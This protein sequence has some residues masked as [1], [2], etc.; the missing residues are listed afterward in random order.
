[1]S[2]VPLAED[3]SVVARRRKVSPEL[4]DV[5]VHPSIRRPV[6][7]LIPYLPEA[8]RKRTLDLVNSGYDSASQF[9]PD[10][11][12][13]DTLAMMHYGVH[14]T[15]TSN[16]K[17]SMPPDGGPPG[18]SPSFAKEQLLDTYNIDAALL[19][20]IFNQARLAGFRIAD[21]KLN[22]ALVSAYNDYMLDVWYGT[23]KRFRWAL[24][25]PLGNMDHSPLP[26]IDAAVAEINRLGSHPG[27]AGIAL[28]QTSIRWGNPLWHPVYEAAVK[29]GL[30]ITTHAGW[31]SAFSF[32]G[33][34]K[35]PVGLPEIWGEVY[36]DNTF[37][38]AAHITSLVM[39][40]VF[41][42]YPTLKL[43]FLEWGATF[44]LPHMWRLDSAW[45]RVRGTVQGARRWPSEI[46]HDQV[47][48][49]TQPIDEPKDKRQFEKLVE[50]YLSDIFCF[51]T[52][53][54]HFDADTP[55]AT[56]TGLSASTKRKIFAENAKAVLRL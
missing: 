32:A 45:P 17:D 9:Q 22:A 50:T 52:D 38:A 53:Y 31:G 15:G 12:R 41:E 19:T 54:P 33:N 13:V 37:Q 11:I 26:D 46:I 51:A 28:N 35:Y 5:D 6:L 49:S 34:A 23:D 18:S 39:N 25:L 48:V 27:V 8:W 1:V 42:R 44:I 10:D 29:E 36:V 55:T 7:D 40:G 43:L 4:I 56:L 47:R 2:A 14:P 24:A 21:P 30:P 3:K 20:G 16:R